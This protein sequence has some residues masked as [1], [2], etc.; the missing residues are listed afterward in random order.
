MM[1][2]H[3]GTPHLKN[4]GHGT[5]QEHVQGQA[6]GRGQGSFAKAN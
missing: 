6:E 5:Q 3:Q 4:V 1:K 2:T